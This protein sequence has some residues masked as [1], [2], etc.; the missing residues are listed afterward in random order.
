MLNIFYRNNG[1]ISVFLT[2]IL[3]PVL[4]MGG[5]TVDA[6]RIY[7]SKVL[8]SDAGEMAMNA[9]LA[10]YDEK[11]HDEYG[12]LV[13]DQ[14]PES[15]AEELEMYFKSSLNE[16]ELP[17][18]DDYKKILDLMTKSF[19]AINIQGSEIYRT[20]VEKQQILEYMKYRAPI[21]LAELLKEKLE[22]LRDTKKITKAMDAQMDFSQA[23]EE[24]QDEFEKAK[25][26]LDTLD[27]AVS[28]FSD[29]ADIKNELSDTEKDY[30]EIVSKCL[31]MREA[32]Q[33][34]D[35]RSSYKGKDLKEMAE[36]FIESA[37]KVSFSAPDIYQEKS[38]DSYMDCLDY[39]KAVDDLGGVSKLLSQDKEAEEGEDSEEDSGSSAGEQEELEEIVRKYEAENTRIFKDF[40]Y[41][42]VLNQTAKQYVDSHSDTLHSYYSTAETAE[43]SAKEARRQLKEVKKKLEKAAD[44]FSKWDHATSELASVNKAGEMENNVNDYREFF[45][46]GGEGGSNLQKLE[47]LM[48]KVQDDEKY[49]SEWKRVLEKEKFFGQSI[50]EVSSSA[51]M[52][53]YMRE[54]KSAVAGAEARYDSVESVRNRYI[55]NYEHTEASN[56]YGLREIKSDEFYRKLKE[57]CEKKEDEDSSEQQR[58]ANQNLEQGKEAAEEAKVEDETVRYNWS[59]AGVTLPSTVAAAGGTEADGALADLDAESNVNNSQAR[60]NTISK[61]KDSIQAANSFL[62]AADQ[63]LSK[64]IE[65]LYIAEYAVQMFSYYTV[66][67]ENGNTRPDADII[68]IS[69]Y[70]LKEHAA[71][72]AECEYILWG[73]PESQKN[74]RNTVMMIFGIRLLFNS[75]FAFTDN[76]INMDS[77]AAATAITGAAPYLEPVV[78]VVIKLGYAGIET[79]NDITKIKQGYGVAIIKDTNTWASIPHHTGGDE[80]TKGSLTLNYPEYLR[81]FLYISLLKDENKAGVLGRIADCIQVNSPDTDLLTSYTMLSVQAEV[82]SRTT[83]MRKISDLGEGGT[84]GFPDD[85]YTIS[86]QSILGY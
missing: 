73:N 24:C 55:T 17:G 51:Q 38:F 76:K 58:Q 18:E 2:L 84:W 63:I 65:N 33:N 44:Q 60:K 59:E 12:L 64:T 5:M 48:S 71:Y 39:K 42:N 35:N 53:T 21:Y 32:I 37:E 83:F 80:N 41:P 45:S 46:D 47:T 40:S 82:S 36:K 34:Y 11:L 75:F 85:T 27:H 30:K 14:S 57:Y 69:G 26:T 74:I 22:Q 25:E 9:G 10:Q 70:S 15:M 61:F 4:I 6:S 86:Y 81:I 43:L 23:M 8:I 77:K 56:S 16:I 19:Q 67:K 49:F 20:E 31:L 66:D 3:L 54:A 50:A 7:M 13:M 52:S 79:A 29:T 78:E 72:R 62:E 1:A 28:A 68:S